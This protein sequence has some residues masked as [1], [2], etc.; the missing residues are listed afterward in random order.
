MDVVQVMCP[1]LLVPLLSPSHS[2]SL[3]L[4]P[5]VGVEEP[6]EEDQN[7]HRWQYFR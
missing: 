1:E 3:L 5:R 2:R 4:L 6:S 7:E